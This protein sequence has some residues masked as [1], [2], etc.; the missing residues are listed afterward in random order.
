MNE[1]NILNNIR[2]IKADPA[3]YMYPKTHIAYARHQNY[4]NPDFLLY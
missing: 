3:T 4:I 2:V 1:I